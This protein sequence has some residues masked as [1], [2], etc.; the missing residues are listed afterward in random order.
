MPSYINPFDFGGPLPPQDMIDR[1]AEARDILAELEGGHWIRL[2]GPRRYGKTTLL[3][4][5]LADAEREDYATALVDLE[6]V[7][8]IGGIVVRIERAYATSLKGRV[9]RFVQNLFSSWGLGLSLGA[10]GFS[11]RLQ[12][13]PQ[14]DAEGAL[15]RVLEVPAE[16]HRRTGHRSLIVFDEVQDL[17]RVDRADG[18]LRS[19]IQHH[20]DAAAYAFA[21]SA[22]GMMEQLFSTPGRPL[23]EQALPLVLGPL[24]PGDVSRYVIER[25]ERTDRE[26]AEALDPLVEFTRGHPQRAMLLAHHVWRGTQIGASADEAVW[27]TALED[28]LAGSVELLRATWRAL[29]VNEQKLALALAQHPRRLRDANVLRQV[30][31]KPGSVKRALD[32][33]LARGDVIAA[34]D[35]LPRLTD[36]LLELWLQRLGDGSGPR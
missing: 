24:N 35:D 30:G 1:D 16:V 28:V 6:D 36:P 13:N 9:R 8:T 29:P 15:L 34:P 21:G 12:A 31:L 11:V 17:L 25:F 2:V 32:G 33:L 27:N 4:R 19:V 14:I 10:G 23:L 26:I 20:R 5:V 7:G 22:P 3:Q 18:I